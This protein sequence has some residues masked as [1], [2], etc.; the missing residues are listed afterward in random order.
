MSVCVC[1]GVCEGEG[2]VYVGVRMCE[3]V[4]AERVDRRFKQ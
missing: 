1:E 4:R 2:N 3:G